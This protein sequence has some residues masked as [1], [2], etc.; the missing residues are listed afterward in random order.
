MRTA[1]VGAFLRYAAPHTD[2]A[3]IAR[4][5]GLP[6]TAIEQPAVSVAPRTLRALCDEVGARLGD[7]AL[8]VHVALANPR[9]TY[10]VTEFAFRSAPTL[11]DALSRLVRYQTLVNDLVRHTF[12]VDERSGVFAQRFPGEPLGGGRYGNEYALAIVVSMGREI[13]GVRW[14]VVRA[15]L[16]HPAPGQPSPEL[17][18]FL[19]TEQIEHGAGHNAIEI[20]SGVLDL[21]VLTHDPALLA[22]VDRIAPLLGPPAD[23]ESIVARTSS[24]IHRALPKGEVQISAIAPQVGL[25]ARTLQRRLAAAGTSFQQLV[26]DVRRRLVLALLES[27]SHPLDEIA[28]RA[29]YSDVRA[30]KRSFRRWTGVTPA[31][32]KRRRH[33]STR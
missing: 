8:G 21:P 24:E 32:W 17:A 18:Q 23:D 4:R 25:T 16:A 27:T 13:T 29:G 12:R 7:P 15:W 26:D 31:G 30:L 20:A 2:A 9:G 5:H 1:M 22:A 3:A 14:P 11:R 28:A 10:G 19:G 6:A 33:P